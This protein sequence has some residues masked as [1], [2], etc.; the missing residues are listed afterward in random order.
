M[1]WEWWDTSTSLNHLKHKQNFQ[2]ADIHVE[3]KVLSLPCLNTSRT[4]YDAEELQAAI[5]TRQICSFHT[6]SDLLV[7]LQNFTMVRI[8]LNF[9]LSTMTKH[10]SCYS[11]CSSIATVQTLEQQN[12]C[13][14]F[15]NGCFSNY[16]ISQLLI[17]KVTFIAV[18]FSWF[19]L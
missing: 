11:K 10:S 16:W 15:R 18:K 2:V 1:S 7:H 12:V 6:N 5:E 4:K 17:K 14:M 9:D 19:H 3:V 13:N 8:L